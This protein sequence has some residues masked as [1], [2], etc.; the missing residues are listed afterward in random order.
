MA[1]VLALLRTRREPAMRH[2]IAAAAVFAASGFAGAADWEIPPA[3]LGNTCGQSA[4]AEIFDC[5]NAA[6][7]QADA[8]LNEVWK[9]VLAKI[10]D[11]DAGQQ[12][13]QQWKSDLVAA[14]QA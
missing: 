13:P 10:A 14:E 4:N 9:K 2:L 5:T 7:K 8:A 1:G 6:Y 3:S 12:D 11:A